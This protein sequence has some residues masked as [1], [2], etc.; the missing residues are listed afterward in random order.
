MININADFFLKLVADKRDS[1]SGP[2]KI[3]V[4]I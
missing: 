1:A 3:Y 4:N 2:E